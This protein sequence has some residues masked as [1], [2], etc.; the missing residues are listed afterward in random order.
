V[1]VNHSYQ[2]TKNKSLSVSAPGVLANASSPIGRSLT[3]VLIGRPAHGTLK[4]K[5]NGSFVYKPK[6]NFKGTDRFTYKVLSRPLVSNVATVTLTV[7]SPPKKAR[8][9]LQVLAGADL[10]KAR[11]FALVDQAIAHLAE[12]ARLNSESR[13]LSKALVNARGPEAIAT[14]WTGTVA[15]GPARERKASSWTA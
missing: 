3:A 7:I 14:S 5:A 11:I 1:A 6:P 9:K 2:L 4:L 8:P 10:S 13:I 15:I 12:R